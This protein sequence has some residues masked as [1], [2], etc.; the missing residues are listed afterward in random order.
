MPACLSIIDCS[1]LSILGHMCV[2]GDVV[3]MLV[4]GTLTELNGIIDIDWNSLYD[5]W[6]WKEGR[7]GQAPAKRACPWA[8]VPRA[9]LSKLVTSRISG[10]GRSR[11]PTRDPRSCSASRRG[12]RAREGAGDRGLGPGGTF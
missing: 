3:G 5:Q 6:M 2:L 12:N 8:K 9:S 7:L 11:S 1:Y 10:L 4:E